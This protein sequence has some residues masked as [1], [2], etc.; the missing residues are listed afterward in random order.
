MITKSKYQFSISLIG[1]SNY[2]DFHSTKFI[3]PKND[4]KFKL[5]LKF[6]KF[7]L[8]AKFIQPNKN[9]KIIN[10]KFKEYLRLN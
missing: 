2:F 7:L 5:F 8:K 10:E 3:Q 1:L 9:F 6:L 4:S